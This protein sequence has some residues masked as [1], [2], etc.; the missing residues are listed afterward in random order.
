MIANFLY[1]AVVVT[2]AISCCRGFPQNGCGFS[3]SPILAGRLPEGDPV[4]GV[5]VVGNNIYVIRDSASYVEVYDASSFKNRVNISVAGMA[6][7]YDM[8]TTGD[9]LLILDWYQYNTVFVVQ[10]PSGSL[11]TWSVGENAYTSMALAE[12]NAFTHG[13]VI[14]TAT[15]SQMVRSFAPNGTPMGS[16]QI[17]SISSP[18]QAIAVSGGTFAVCSGYGLSPAVH[19]VCI[20][21][22]QGVTKKCYGGAPGS[23]VGQLNIPARLLLN[24]E[25]CIL[26]ADDGNQRVVLLDREL[27]YVEDLL[28]SADGLQGPYRLHLDETNRLLYVADNTVDSTGAATSGRVFVFKTG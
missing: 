22:Q 1:V 24:R 27:A 2:T 4:Y 20:V 10:I 5:A 16:F 7:P 25:K 21:N 6:G 19:E 13:N 15:T 11:T 17:Q 23:G 26:V 12:P 3:A 9:A 14:V 18:R 28:T 8:V